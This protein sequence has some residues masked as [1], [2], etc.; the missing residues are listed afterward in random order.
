M[1]NVTRQT[2]IMRYGEGYA[3]VVAALEGITDAELDAHT[4]VEEWTVRQIVHHL[5]DSEMT[6]GIRL[7]RLLAE[8][9]PVISGYDEAEF[10]RRLHYERPIDT[11][12]EVL[13]AVRAS[14]MSLLVALTEAEWERTG[15]HSE[16]G[17]YS[18]A[19]W[20][21][22]YGLHAHDH[23]DQIRRIRAASAG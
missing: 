17:G 23:A 14:A 8:E 10:A 2:L 7:R 19:S 20:L 9:Q 4:P 18:V 1:E 3:A 21:D 16:S 13:R 15:T 11:S 22:I 5:C 6:S 12:L